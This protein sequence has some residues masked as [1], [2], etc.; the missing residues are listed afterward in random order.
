MWESM[1][2]MAWFS[3][4][5]SMLKPYFSK[6]PCVVGCTSLLV[7]FR[8]LLVTSPYPSYPI[9]A[10]HCT[11]FVSILGVIKMEVCMA[12]YLPFGD[13]LY[14]IGFTTFYHSTI[15]WIKPDV[16]I[17]IIIYIYIYIWYQHIHT[18]TIL[19]IC[20]IYIYVYVYV[21]CYV[22]YYVHYV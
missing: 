21:Y 4:C 20:Y 9:Q 11:Q 13:G 12:T 5:W 14:I 7:V 3:E 17:Y 6:M 22:Y 19:C 2:C 18:Y 16:R 15:K 8:L 10:I 1:R